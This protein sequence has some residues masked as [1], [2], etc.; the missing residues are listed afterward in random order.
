MFSSSF[1]VPCAGHPFGLPVGPTDIC[2]PVAVIP[3][4]L[5]IHPSP[6]HLF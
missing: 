5:S 3:N 2:Q 1:H 6:L 4:P